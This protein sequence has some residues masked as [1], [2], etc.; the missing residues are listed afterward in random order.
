LVKIVIKTRV[1]A[2][3]FKKVENKGFSENLT[4]K[5]N[6]SETLLEAN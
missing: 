3:R 6:P 4:A 5:M 2:D 1:R